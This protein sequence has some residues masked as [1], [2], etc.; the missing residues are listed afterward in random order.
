MSG[1][2]SPQHRLARDAGGVKHGFRDFAGCEG[3]LVI[4]VAHTFSPFQRDLVMVMNR[5][6]RFIDTTAGRSGH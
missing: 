5:Q 1:S 3:S 2:A 6:E 4:R